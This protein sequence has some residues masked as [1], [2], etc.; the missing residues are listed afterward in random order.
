MLDDE[1]ARAVL[2][3]LKRFHADGGTIVVATH[4]TQPDGYADRTLLM[5]AGLIE[6]KEA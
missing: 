4:G 3:C 2:D 1:N 5:R 6:G